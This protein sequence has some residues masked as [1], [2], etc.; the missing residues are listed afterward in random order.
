MNAV[1]LFANIGVAEAYLKEIGINIVVANEIV[2]RR[3]DLYSE[4]YPESKMICGDINDEIIYS[5]IV[6]ECIYNNVEIVIATPPCQGM[7]TAGPR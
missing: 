6:N 7:S 5:A 2:K 1:S 4:I 3:A